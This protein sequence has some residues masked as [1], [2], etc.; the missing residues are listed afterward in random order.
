MPP[1]TQTPHD[2]AILS[3]GDFTRRVKELLETNLPPCWVR[4]EISNLRRQHSG[5][6]Y[7]TL[8]DAQSQVSCVLFR[9]DAMRQ[10]VDL[11][12]GLQAIVYGQVSVYEPRGT[13]QLICRVVMD[14]GA[15]RLQQEFER[16]KAKLAAEGLFEAER[17]RPL[18]P[19]P[20]AVG[21]VTSP[22][23][24][25]IRDFLS[26]LARRQWRGRVVVIPAQ[27]QGA[28]AAAQIVA[29]IEAAQRLD[30]LDLLVV[31][32]GGG[33]LED[34]WCFNEESVARAVAAC[35]LP[36]ISAVGHEIDFTLSDFAADKRAETPSAA[37]ELISSGY[38]EILDRLDLARD[39]LSELAARTLERLGYRMQSARAG[40]ESHHPR[41]RLEQAS[42]RLDDLGNRL[43][44]NLRH[45]L[46]DRRSVLVKSIHGL[47]AHTPQAVLKLSAV[48]LKSARE[49]MGR[50]TPAV[51]R[52]K[53][54]HLKQ[55]C[56]R[57]ENASLQKA[58]DRG[59]AVAR[60]ER[61]ELVSAKA[62]LLPG[63][64]LALDFKDGEILVRVEDM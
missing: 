5:H 45:L 39:G 22:T 12:D 20:R 54:E 17:K 42:L 32:R 57:L 55:L 62:G 24:A 46:S 44:A 9:G 30:G 4:G 40:L 43:R 58:L 37:A 56:T 51:L 26:I 11:R 48:Q 34:L 53:R 16:L 27:V 19:L 14:D 10:Q 1:L 8:K 23:G 61:G 15:G 38:L 6:V 29:G 25:A 2:D 33:S 64:R 35:S 60:D 50:Q 59:F 36:V 31:G 49:R 47:A 7:F 52:Q 3:V 28:G 13:H 21:F 63:Q 41:P 18:P